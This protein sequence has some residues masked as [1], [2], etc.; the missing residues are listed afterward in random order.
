MHKK[1]LYLKNNQASSFGHDSMPK[2]FNALEL[3]KPNFVIKLM[4]TGASEATVL[5]HSE[6][7]GTVEYVFELAVPEV[8][9]KDTAVTE[10][11]LVKFMHECVLPLAMQTKALIIMAAGNDC[12]LATATAKVLAPVQQRLG[13]ECPFTTVGMR[14]VF[15]YHKTV[16]TEPGSVAS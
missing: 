5:A 2:I 1:V 11:Q 9:K 15:E 6:L 12:A 14:Y 3:K 13:S 8:S 16:H 4:H 10:R 7:A